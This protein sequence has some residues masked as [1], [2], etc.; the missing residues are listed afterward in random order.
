DRMLVIGSGA[1]VDHQGRAAARVGLA[2]QPC[3]VTREGPRDVG[4]AVEV[5]DHRLLAREV[6][7]EPD[8]AGAPDH[9]HLDRVALEHGAGRVRAAGIGIRRTARAPIPTASRLRPIP[10]AS[11]PRPSGR[12]A[13]DVTSLTGHG[14]VSIGSLLV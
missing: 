1:V 11:C 3:P 7:V 13:A 4:T 6:T 8:A 2:G 14:W 9:L 10:A 5:D 12:L